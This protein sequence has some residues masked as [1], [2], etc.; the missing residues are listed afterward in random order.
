[1]EEAQRQT[2][3]AREQARQ[4]ESERLAKDLFDS[5]R[6][7]ES[8]ADGLAQRQAFA[9]ATTA[10]RDATQSFGQARQQAS[11]LLPQLREAD[12]KRTLMQT[13]KQKAK[14]DLPDYRAGAAQERQGDAT[15]ARN[16]FK[17]AGGHYDA[18][19]SLYAKAIAREEPED[20]IRQALNTYK[21]AIEGK[22]LGLYQKVYPGVTRD[23]LR[24][25]EAAFQALQSQ[26]LD[27][28][29]VN[30][31]INGDDATARGRRFDVLVPRGGREIRNE[32]AF[33]IRLRRTAS[34]WV[35]QEMK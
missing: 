14:Q 33:S 20:L 6:T 13:E 15:Y 1:M 9:D 29:D 2:Y 30:I 28:K 3:A 24:K 27:F 26:T 8:T 18:A 25:V 5:G 17:E 10:Y 22:D 21:R 16:A 34:G 7:K 32:S 31:D 4:S 11:A 12:Q 19:R 23:N 35:I